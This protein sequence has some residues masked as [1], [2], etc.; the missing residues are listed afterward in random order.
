[1]DA[2]LKLL[3]HADRVAGIREGRL[4]PPVMVDVDPVDGTCNLDC[5]W[6]CQAA[7]RAS[8]PARFMTAATM[9]GLGRFCAEWG[10]ESWRISGDGEPTLNKDLSELIR[11][12][13][14]NGIDVGLIT[15]GLLLDRV[16]R[17]ALARLTYL[18][19]S[20]D[21]A[22]PKTWSRLKRSDPENFQR[23]LRNL[24]TARA[25]A[26]D[27]D[28]SIKYLRWRHDTHLS[29]REFVRGDLP[30]IDGEAIEDTDTLCD[31]ERLE[32]PAAE[33]GVRTIVKDAFPRGMPASYGFGTCHATPLGGVFDAS[34]RFHLCCD[35][36]NVYVLTDDYTRDDWSELKSLWGG[37]RH[38]ELIRSITPASCVGCAKHRINR[39]LEEIVI[40][41]DPR[42]QVN[43]I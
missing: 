28:I 39:T 5:E 36:R 4:R 43:F 15:N 3:R 24:A 13:T 29:K 32:A 7:S 27:L 25:S 26:P 37:A 1:M 31:I 12:G 16:D 30:V 23:I 38:L 17:D 22:T 34:H 19:V 42:Q 21:A 41:P 11:S 14:S 10:V 2:Q 40:D 20:L 35:A 33:L 8:R 18:G 6:C 9:E